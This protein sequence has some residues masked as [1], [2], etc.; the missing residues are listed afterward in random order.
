M[1]NNPF[2]KTTN[3]KL[4]TITHVFNKTGNDYILDAGKYKVDITGDNNSDN[5]SEIID[6]TNTN[7]KQCGDKNE[8]RGHDCS[9]NKVIDK[10]KE[11]NMIKN[12]EKIISKVIN[13]ATGKN[14]ASRE[15]IANNTQAEITEANEAI[16]KS[17]SELKTINGDIDTELNTLNKFKTNVIESLD[18]LLKLY[19]KFEIDTTVINTMKPLTNKIIELFENVYN[20]SLLYSIKNSIDAKK[21][22]IDNLQKNVVDNLHKTTTFGFG[23]GINGQSKLNLFRNAITKTDKILKIIELLNNIKDNMKNI[24]IKDENIPEKENYI[25]IEK[26]LVE[27]EKIVVEVQKNSG[28]GSKKY[29]RKQSRK[30]SKKYPRKQSRKHK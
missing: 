28:G 15:A 9:K 6:Y 29:S 13:F 22:E 27:L 24:E 19:N 4:L 17:E 1:S 11:Y 14:T 23:I 2:E 20:T 21:N 25:I 26:D 16:T 10:L 8:M 5:F 30:Q 3:N 12:N 18:K 7:F